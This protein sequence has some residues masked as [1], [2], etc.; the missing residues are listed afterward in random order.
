MFKI[1]RIKGNRYF[2]LSLTR[3]LTYDSYKN[4]LNITQYPWVDSVYYSYGERIRLRQNGFTHTRNL[5]CMH[6]LYT[7]DENQNP[8]QVLSI[9]KNL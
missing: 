7:V 5:A 3:V 4:T 9:I 1:I 8:I 6:N 2:S